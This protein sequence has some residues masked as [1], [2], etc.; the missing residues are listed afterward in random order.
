MMNVHM[1]IHKQMG[2]EKTRAIM[3]DL[4]DN[5]DF[6]YFQTAGAES[7]GMYKVK[8]LDSEDAVATYLSECGASSIKRLKTVKQHGGK[9]YLFRVS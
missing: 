9:R 1:W 3:H 4:I 6:M 2:E 5:C 8:S 7:S